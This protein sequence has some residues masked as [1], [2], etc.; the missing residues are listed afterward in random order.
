MAECVG[1]VLHIA[2][3]PGKCFLPEVWQKCITL[4]MG[5]KTV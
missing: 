4:N 2:E 1:P 3:D 5:E